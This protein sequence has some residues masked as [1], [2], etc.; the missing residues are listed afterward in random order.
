MVKKE[1]MPFEGKTINI[2]CF[3][4]RE[5]FLLQG[6]TTFPSLWLITSRGT[7]NELMGGLQQKLGTTRKGLR[8][9]IAKL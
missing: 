4:S 2:V 1:L 9:L 7:E 3:F 5:L 8:D 6:L